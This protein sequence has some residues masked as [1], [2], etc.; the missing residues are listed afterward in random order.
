MNDPE[1]H[2]L[3]WGA[4]DVALRKGGVAFEHG[5]GGKDLWQVYTEHPEKGARFDEM[6]EVMSVREKF[7]L[8]EEVDW[9]KIR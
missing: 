9:S 7:A 2:Q 6:M 8:A 1:D 5:T 4:L 3:G